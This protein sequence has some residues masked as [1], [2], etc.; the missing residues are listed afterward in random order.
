MTSLLRLLAALDRPSGFFISKFQHFRFSAFQLLPLL[1][2]PVLHAQSPDDFNPGANNPV[3]AI[4][5]QP[6]G[7]VLVGGSFS[8]IGG[9]VRS[10]LARLNADGTFDYAFNPGASDSVNSLAVQSDGKI[11]VGGG[12]TTLGGQPRN[13]IARLNAD[14]SLDSSFNPD[15][16]GFLGV[17]SLALQTDGKVL[18]GGDFTTIGGQTCNRIARL[19][20]NGSLDTGFNPDVDGSVHS[21]AVQADGK[22]LVGGYFTNI[23]GQP[24]NGMARLNADGSLDTSFNL[25]TNTNS[26]V[27]SFAMQ[28]DGKVLVGGEF[29]TIGGQ[30]RNNIAR[31]HA[32]GSLDTGFN[33]NVSGGFGVV[34]LVV[35]TDG[36]VLLGGSFYS[37]GG[38][39]RSSI[40][41]LNSDGSLDLGF[42]PI[43]DDQ[44]SSLALQADGKVLLGGHFGTIDSQS[45][46]RLARLGNNP[47]TSALS[48]TGTSQID[49]Q[50]GGTAPEVAQVAFDLWDGSV[51]LNLGNPVRVSG[52]WRMT[53]LTL[54][55]SSWV[56]ARDRTSNGGDGSGIVEQIVSYGTI[57]KP[58]IAVSV[59]GGPDLTSGAATLDFGT[60]NGIG[61]FPAKTIKI[62]NV[63]NAPL[64]GLGVSVAG[65]HS[66]AFQVGIL[67]A[68]ILAPGA[69]T[70][71]TVVFSPQV[72]GTIGAQILITSNDAD[73]HPFDIGLRGGGATQVDDR[74]TPSANDS[75]GVYSLAVQADG[76]ILVGGAFTSLG[77][78]PRN[79]LARLNADGSL[80]NGFN[81]N[82][83]SWVHSLAVQTD[84]KVLV[85]GEFTTVGGVARNYIARLNADGSLDNAFN[86]DAD[87]IVYSLALQLD[88]RI[89]VGGSFTSIGGTTRTYIARLNANGSLQS[90]FNP[91]V[92]GNVIN[93]LAVQAD[94]KILLG[95]YFFSINGVERNQI[96]RLNATGSLDT[97][98][99]P[100]GNGNV[101]A[102][103][104]QADGKILI[105]GEFTTIGEQSRNRT[106]RL[107]ANG[108]LDTGFSPD[109]NGTVDSLTV[110]ADGKVLVGGNF[111]MI[112]GQPHNGIA[113]LNADGSLDSSFDQSASGWVNSL[114]LQADGKVLVGGYFTSIGG[115][116]RNHIAR[117]L[118]YPATS[119]LTVTGTS[120]IDWLRGGSAPEVEQVRFESWSG[121][122]RVSAGTASRVSG[123]WRAT[124]LSLPVS[125]WIRARGRTSS[126]SSGLVEQI[127]AYGSGILPDISVEDQEL[128]DLSSGSS[129]VKWLSPEI[130]TPLTQ[131]F[132]IRN[133]GAATLDGLNASLSGPGAARFS[134]G[135]LGANSLLPGS[136]MVLN[137]TF[138]PDSTI[139]ASAILQITSND[140]DESPFLV[141]LEG[142]LPPEIA[143]E[144]P[145]GN[146]LSSGASSDWGQV[147]L[148]TPVMRFFTVRN[149]GSDTLNLGSITVTRPQ[150]GDY[151]FFAAATAPSLPSSGQT[152]I[153]ISFTPSA[154]GTR[155]AV[156][157]IPNN[158]PNES[159]FILNLSGMGV[160]PVVSLSAAPASVAEDAGAPVFTFTRNGSTA[161]PLT[162][163]FTVGGTAAFG[164]DYSQSGADSFTASSGTVTFA[165]GAS[166]ATVTLD[167]T[168]DTTVE[169]DE[170]IALTLAA[171]SGYQ[172]ATQNAAM[173]TIVN[174]DTD[175]S[176]AV[177]PASVVEDG[178]GNL[179]FTFTRAE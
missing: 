130:G 8:F 179:V 146:D 75:Y 113:R 156:L 149:T 165:V 42:N 10:C 114:A 59:D 96:A 68:T 176:V 90:S 63:G 98:F 144:Q 103:A 136:Q 58:D 105:G 15:A 18:L 36:K 97:G 9:Q 138:T 39:T 85:G 95:G 94:G 153:R 111:A 82:P 89:L 69:S 55:A 158:D 23:G 132:T 173:G 4:A 35:Q 16:N 128:N 110:Q 83:N 52:G 93:S 127:A 157:N 107:N 129:E 117:L 87:S 162:V 145:Q 27:H 150:S 61:F 17:R 160:P 131:V 121:S 135:S 34:S 174:D 123:G 155:D 112:G 37:V 33:P 168:A 6:D 154:V 72:P 7:K 161:L 101:N 78:Q 139:P 100:N 46:I 30:P 167:P 175:V 116:P 88:G 141:N 38:Q 81:P 48:V 164:S 50:R 76:K 92:N 163:N 11:L 29:T 169:P 21:L 102:L 118:N 178:A 166:S 32:D 49:W 2:A 62:T 170:T 26:V 44:I 45:R 91:N 14:G 152:T 12:F 120:Q 54:P 133:A 70:S 79:Y 80:D 147:I 137:V 109:A 106:A 19:N 51:W 67:G 86:P 151:E 56:R 122:T 134:L 1:L 126:G 140:L 65:V 73:E 124:G 24:R 22:V 64:T 3:D 41:R 53:G 84:G 119:S 143:V 60:G 31:L 74:F 25:G 159:P 43:L 99:N 20:V 142:T 104:V 172:V 57:S 115:Q 148:G 5:I 13:G 47:A 77:G 28:A 177:S 71:F 171:G 66:A 108:S 40:A 125:T